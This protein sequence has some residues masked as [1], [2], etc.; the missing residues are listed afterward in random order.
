MRLEPLYSLRFTYPEEWGV[1]LADPGS[2]ESQ[3]FF[4]AEGRCEGRISAGFA[5]RII[6]AAQTERSSPTSGVIETD[7]EATIY[8]DFGGYGQAYPVGRRQIVG[9]AG[10]LSD[11]ER[12]RWLNDTVSVSTGEVRVME[13]QDTVL[14]LETA[15]LIWEPRPNRRSAADRPPAL[16]GLFTAGT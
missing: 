8:F 15:E 5:V 10:H 9:Y 11:D 7:D 3:W 1:N 6:P 12:Y 13:G 14:V 16:A 2:T 4:I